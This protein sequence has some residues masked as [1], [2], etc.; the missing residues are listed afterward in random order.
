MARQG[1][2]KMSS[3]AATFQQ[4]APL[5]TFS[6]VSDPLKRSDQ[7]RNA[8]ARSH[9]KLGMVP[10]YRQIVPAA[11]DGKRPSPIGSLGQPPL[12]LHQSQFPT[13]GFPGNAR[14]VRQ[15]RGRDCHLIVLD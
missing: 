15:S 11:I 12:G 1:L 10:S 14:N 3:L 4:S 9:V 13:Y 6:I 7:S 8:P 2:L 5:S